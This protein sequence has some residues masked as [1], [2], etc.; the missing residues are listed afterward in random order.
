[1]S[2]TRLNLPPELLEAVGEYKA[3]LR[4]IERE[5]APIERRMAA[6]IKKGEQLDKADQEKLKSLSDK[7]DSLA[8]MV[9]QRKEAGEVARDSFGNRLWRVVNTHNP[10]N[11]IRRV[12]GG[13]F[14]GSDVNT[15]GEFLKTQGAK[16]FAAGNVRT[17]AALAKLGVNVSQSA[18]MQGG[19]YAMVALA[20]RKAVGQIEANW[21]EQASAFRA[22]GNEAGQFANFMLQNRFT[23]RLSTNDV[24]NL[25]ATRRGAIQGAGDAMR[26]SSIASQIQ[27]SFLGRWM[28]LN[29]NAA[30]EAEARASALSTRRFTADRVYGSHRYRNLHELEHS[31]EVERKVDESG[32]SLGVSPI[33]KFLRYHIEN[34][35]TG[36]QRE[37]AA[38]HEA[39]EHLQ[40]KELDALHQKR[41]DAMKLHQLD[42]YKRAAD[43]ERD[44]RINSTVMYDL[45]RYSD[46]NKY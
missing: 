19:I 33:H 26:G 45:K 39:A 11:A 32:R 34:F 20:V 22:Q 27:N 18:A 42:P 46:W 6:A 25:A 4:E 21:E 43:M 44:M 37:K 41:Q 2:I 40:A 3:A 23:G 38:R 5:L 24:L 12:L 35:V 16:Q 13:N 1:M 17:G 28:G 10:H 15:I 8:N 36:G 9:Q 7:R 30:T 31:N 14:L 29:D